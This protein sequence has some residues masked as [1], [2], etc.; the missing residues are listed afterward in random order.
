VEAG[1][2]PDANGNVYGLAVQADGR[3]LVGG[4]FTSVGGMERTNLARLNADGTL[5]TG[6]NANADDPVYSVA[7]QA[8]A[9]FC[10]EAVSPAWA[11]RR[12]TAWRGLMPTAR[13]TQ[14][15]TR[16]RTLVSIA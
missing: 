7:L 12:E 15:L 13:S 10:W 1:F 14:G 4:S 3:I 16:M 11:G 5:D 9:R 2:N 6:F 8:D